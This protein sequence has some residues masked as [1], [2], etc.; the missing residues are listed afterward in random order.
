MRKIYVKLILVVSA[1]IF[2]TGLSPMNSPDLEP[3]AYSNLPVG[4]NFIIAGYVYTAG[5]VLFDPEVPLDNANIKIH[6]SVFAYARSLKI[7]SCS[8]APPEGG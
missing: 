8:A 5:A 3:R 4:L 7:G 1:C 2:L 6:G